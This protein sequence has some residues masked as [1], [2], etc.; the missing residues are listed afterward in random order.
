MYVRR[1]DIIH[2]SMYNIRYKYKY[3]ISHVIWRCPAK[4]PRATLP[5]VSALCVRNIYH[6]ARA[7]ADDLFKAIN[8]LN[9]PI[10]IRPTFIGHVLSISVSR[11]TPRVYLIYVER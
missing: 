2:I 4:R 9:R 6:V 1:H 11:V 5:K 8:G 3:Y 7:R 10:V